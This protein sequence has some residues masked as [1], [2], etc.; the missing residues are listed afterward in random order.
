[1]AAYLNYPSTTAREHTNVRNFFSFAKRRKVTKRGAWLL[2]QGRHGWAL[3]GTFQTYCLRV[4]LPTGC[5]S[6]IV[7]TERYGIYALALAARQP[8]FRAVLAGLYAELAR[9]RLR[10]P[11]PTRDFSGGGQ[12]ALALCNTDWSAATLKGTADR[13][14][15][16][17]VAW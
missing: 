9:V 13:R 15:V 17:A 3:L 11:W 2:P 1:M 14:L 6:I 16:A 12:P 8:F 4:V 7:N 10:V 5:A